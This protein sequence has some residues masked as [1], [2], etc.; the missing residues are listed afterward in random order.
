MSKYIGAI[1]L[2][3]E[4]RP[5]AEQ[6]GSAPPPK[7]IVI[8]AIVAK[9]GA[10]T[11]PSQSAPTR[12]IAAPWFPPRIGIALMGFLPPPCFGTLLRLRPKP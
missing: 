10:A 12:A 3:S 2:M 8:S 9:A 5:N 1:P 4:P 6:S 7:Q 11:R